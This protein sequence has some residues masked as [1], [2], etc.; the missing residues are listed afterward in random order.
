MNAEERLVADYEGTGVTLA[1]HT[2]AYHRK[3]L[4]QK[5]VTSANDLKKLRHN[6]RVTTRQRP[7]TAKGIIF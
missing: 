5:G 4:D 3:E 2:M 7:G 1:R 6:Q